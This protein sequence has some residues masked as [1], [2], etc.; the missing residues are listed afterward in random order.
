MPCASSR[1]H[2]GAPLTALVV[3][4]APF[5]L[6]VALHVWVIYSE[7][8]EKGPELSQ[9]RL[10]PVQA[11]LDPQ[12]KNTTTSKLRASVQEPHRLRHA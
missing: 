10:L 4:A 11:E 1:Y 2:E 5:A 6:P 12:T 3:G 7:D 8:T 9:S